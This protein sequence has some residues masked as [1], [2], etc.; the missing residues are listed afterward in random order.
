MNFQN[1]KPGEKL[2]T[3]M[4]M[5]VLNVTSTGI[6]VKDSQGRTFEVRGK[7]LIEKSFKS[8]NQTSETKKVTRTELA[9]MLTN[10][11]DQV[12]TVNFD[13]QTGEN[14]TLVGYKVSSE[15]LMGRINVIDL[16]KTGYNQR[17]VDLRTTKYAIINGVKYQVK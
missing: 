5:E 4:Y 8:A 12:F 1:I 13:K 3:T 17:Q 2:S 10:L 7:E 6:N 11:G 14:R 15:N 16:E 9:E